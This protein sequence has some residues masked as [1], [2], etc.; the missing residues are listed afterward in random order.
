MPEEYRYLLDNPKA[1]PSVRS[2]VT[3]P[4]GWCIVE[5]DYATAELRAW[6]YIAGDQQMIDL[7]TKPDPCFAKVKPEKMVDDDCVCRLTFPEYIDTQEFQEYVMTYTVDNK[8]LARFTEEDLV[9]DKDGN[10]VNSKQDLHWGLAEMMQKRP[11]EVLSKKADRSG[12]KVANFCLSST[13]VVLTPSGWKK[14]PDVL[15]SDLVWDGVEWVSHGGVVWRGVRRVFDYQG[16]RGTFEHE[17]FTE[18]CV[19]PLHLAD[20]IRKWYTLTRPELPEGYTAYNLKDTP[21]IGDG[22]DDTYDILDAGP[23][24]RFTC[25][26]V[27]VSN[28][29]AYGAS[30]NTLERKIESDTGIKPLPGTGDKLLETLMKRQPRA[31]EFMEEMEKSVEDPGYIVAASGRVRHFHV[32]SRSTVGNWNYKGVVSALGR[33][34]RNYQMQESVAATAARASSWMW[35]FKRLFGLQGR[36]IAVLYDSVVTLCP[37]EEREIWKLA[38]DLFMY[39]ANGWAYEDR[40]LTYPVD[41]ELNQSWSMKPTEKELEAILAVPEGT[42]ENQVAAKKWLQEKLAFV[43]KFPKM[44]V[45]GADWMLKATQAQE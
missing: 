3:A 37:S 30:G 24:N 17:V 34:G 7:L 2:I 11:R 39:E 43:R 41:H 20:V 23:R 27:L 33:E 10:L 8:V 9:K 21:D 36:P 28:S 22:L 35:Q 25:N 32:H 19:G 44:S 1:L 38:H 13:C 18:D 29:T 14:I 16:L 15:P 4:P 5:S 31:F 42:K 40:I 6:A 12:S 45:K 26:N